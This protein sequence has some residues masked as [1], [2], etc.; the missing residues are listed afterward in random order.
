MPYNAKLPAGLY[1][2]VIGETY[3]QLPEI[4]RRFHDAPDRSTVTGTF[5]VTRGAG[6]LRNIV[7]GLMGLP[8]AGEAVPVHLAIQL[9]GAR[10]LW[11][12][13]FGNQRF[14]TRQWYCNGLL[15]EAAGPVRFGFRVTASP[16]HMEFFMERFWLHSLP[17][18]LAMAPRV[19]AVVYG[20]GSSWWTI[21][22]VEA[23]LIGLLVKYEGEMIPEC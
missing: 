11:V 7:A 5:Q 15:I 12:R 3:D 9:A 22:Q 8:S 14:V 16:A 10:E 19:H 17:V 23:P 13:T 18:P 20:R 21:V 4:L 2:Q 1:R 6:V